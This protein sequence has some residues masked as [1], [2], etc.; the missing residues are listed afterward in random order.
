MRINVSKSAAEGLTEIL[1]NLVNGG[2]VDKD[3]IMNFLRNDNG[4]KAQFKFYDKNFTIEE[5]T[6]AFIKSAKNEKYKTDNDILA[7]M[8]NAL[9]RISKNM[10]L[11][12]KKINNIKEYDFK[13]LESKLKDTLPEDT[14]FDF[15]IFF[16][17]DGNNAG[18]IVD[19]NTMCLDALFWASD[20]NK[21]EQVEGIILHEFHHIGCLYWL[22]KNEK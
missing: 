19:K 2:N 9:M 6:D 1:R 8:N 20:K 15:N 11:L 3:S 14:Q 5:Y 18:S 16:C 21:E 4:C 13:I 7:R 12:E 10:D 17:L 22:N